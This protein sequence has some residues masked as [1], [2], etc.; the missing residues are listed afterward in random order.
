MGVLWGES[1]LY[2]T[3]SDFVLESISAGCAVASLSNN[4]DLLS[5]SGDVRVIL[6]NLTLEAGGKT[7]AMH[8]GSTG[9]MFNDATLSSGTV[10]ITISGL[11]T[12]DRAF[13][14]L[15]T[16]SGTLGTHYKAVCTANTLTITA[17]DITGSTVTTDTSTLT[18][19]IIKK[20]N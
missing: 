4:I 18:Y 12:T 17:V 15:T 9:D 14:Q 8:H 5:S 2:M 11:A 3:E 20:S 16:P 7:I 6:S 1:Y 13:L 10:A 19:H